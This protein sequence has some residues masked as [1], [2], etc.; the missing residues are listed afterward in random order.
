VAENKDINTEILFVDLFKSEEDFSPTT[1]YND[2]AISDY[3]FHWQSQNKTRE[4]FG[5]G[6]T[7]IDHI[8]LKKIILLFVREKSENEFKNTIGYLFL[9]Q[10]NYDNHY[11]TK[12]MSITWKLEEPMPNSLWKEAAKLAVG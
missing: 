6:L 4:D 2:Y 9:G 8:N 12:P 5:K 11:G 3:L 1:M 10:V 7:Y